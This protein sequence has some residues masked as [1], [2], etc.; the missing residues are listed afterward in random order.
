MRGS[1]LS[2]RTEETTSLSQKE[3]IW[4]HRSLS[5]LDSAQSGWKNQLVLLEQLQFVGCSPVLRFKQ[6]SPN[7]LN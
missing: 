7:E 2:I 4:I 1:S 3:E 5:V 6:K